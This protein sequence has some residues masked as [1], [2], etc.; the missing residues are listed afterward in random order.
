MQDTGT[1]GEMARGTVEETL[2]AILDF[3][4]HRLC[5]AGRYKG[6]EA[7]MGTRASSD[8]RQLQAKTGEVR[9]KVPKLRIL[10]PII[11]HPETLRSQNQFPR[12][13]GL[14]IATR[15]I[16]LHSTYS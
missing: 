6:I 13:E 4:T 2:T 16:A 14:S 11:G 7:R 3:E 8:G 15:S 10:T 12:I 1:L 9:M 5:P